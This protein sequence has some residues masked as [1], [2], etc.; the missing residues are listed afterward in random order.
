MLAGVRQSTG[1]RTNRHSPPSI[2]V[3]TAPR[4]RQTRKFEGASVT[5]PE[6]KHRRRLFLQG[7]VVI[8]S[9]SKISEAELW[10]KSAP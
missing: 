9:G 10:T 1:F 4:W 7:Q 3:W 6:K 2:E 8:L 5:V